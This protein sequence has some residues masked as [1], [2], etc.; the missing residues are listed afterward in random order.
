M[1]RPSSRSRRPVWR[2]GVPVACLLAGLL[3][4]ADT[5]G[6]RWQGDPRQ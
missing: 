4:G 2:Y 1:A 5:W 3:L 6:V